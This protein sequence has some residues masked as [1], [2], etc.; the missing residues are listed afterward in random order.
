[1]K[2]LA[3]IDV[4]TT[5][6]NPYRLDRVVEVAVVLVVPGQGIS[7]ELTTL[8]NPERDIG[9][10]SVHG[11]TASDIINAPRFAQIAGHLAE[12]LCGSIAL[13]GHNVRFDVS[14]LQSEYGRISVEMPHYASLDT[15]ALAG[16]GTLSACCTEHGIKYHGKA[17]AA[18]HDARAAAALLQ[19]MLLQIPDLLAR[20]V[21][22]A[23]PTWPVLHTPSGTLLPRGSL[24]SATPAVPS[25]VQR[26]A[27][28]LSAGSG[29]ASQ[30]EGERDYRALLW[31]TLEDGRV[32]EYEGNSL[33]DVATRWGLSFDRVKAIHLDYL[34]Q[35]AKAAWADRRIT[36]AERREIQLVAQLLGFGRLSDDQLHNLLGSCDST[37]LSD[38]S[39]TL[40]EEWTG[41]AV[42]FTGE[43]GCSMRGQLIT[44]E[45]AE[46]LAVKK[47]LR[48]LP[49]VTKKLDLLVVPDP[50][51]QSG[52][53]KKARQYGIRIVHE[54]VFWRSLGVPID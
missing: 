8:V 54:P 35:L 11:L 50:N 44:R 51:T 36:E 3:V 5:G 40:V 17:H 32:E 52:K 47:G 1:M 12:F 38:A 24:E 26:L 19:R 31:R 34:S 43:C 20:L 28:R 21:P 48:V 23:P 4:E 15:M 16:G 46:Q 14:F 10:T 45:M 42:C 30:P 37:A 53:A 25:Y 22:C 41:K 7:A 29:D 2:P 18:L 39:A 6:L 13:V 27:D 33:V 9:P 49:S